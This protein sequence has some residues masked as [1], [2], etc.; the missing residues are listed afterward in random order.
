MSKFFV[1][2]PALRTVGSHYYEYAMPLLPWIERAGWEP[3]LAVHRKFRD[4]NGVAAEWNVVPVFAQGEAWSRPPKR[5]RCGGDG[6]GDKRGILGGTLERVAAWCRRRRWRR[7]VRQFARSCACLNEQVPIQRGDRVLVASM[8]DLDLMG[9]VDFLER[10]PQARHARWNAV[11]HCTI[12]HG[13]E[14]ESEAERIWLGQVRHRFEVARRCLSDV[15]LRLFNTTKELA[16]Q[17]VQWVDAG[18]QELV[19]PVSLR[20]IPSGQRQPPRSPLRVVCP[21]E[22]R[23]EKGTDALVQ[24]AREL[25]N[26]ELD[27]GRMQL[28]VQARQP[29]EVRRILETPSP[30]AVATSRVSELDR[31]RAPIIAVPHPL[32]SDDYAALVGQTDVGLLLYDRRRYYARCSGILLEMLCAGVPVVVPAACWLAEQL[33]VPNEQYLDELFKSEPICGRVELARVTAWPAK[34]ATS[35]RVAPSGH[36]SEHAFWWDVPERAGEVVVSVRPACGRRGQFVSLQLE[37]PGADATPRRAVIPA[38]R[39]ETHRVAFALGAHPGA[40]GLTVRNAYG[41]GPI[42]LDHVHLDFLVRST[43]YPQRPL[44]A[45]GLATADTYEVPGLLK[46]ILLHREHYR[47]TARR[48]SAAFRRRHSPGATVRQLLADHAFCDSLREEAKVA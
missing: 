47:R 10:C 41:D 6:R 37:V 42:E 9:L 48:W 35:D 32:S 29:N 34:G 45:V 7:D 28:V 18:F 2:Q 3:V 44:A 46:E 24:V 27:S 25:W 17:Y 33:A 30:D 40:I 15:D 31:C 8:G 21:G 39:Q 23:R 20:V 5:S 38:E 13:W 26:D 11:F 12:F 43:K 36:V 1:L 4:P 19:Y 22:L 14:P 16:E